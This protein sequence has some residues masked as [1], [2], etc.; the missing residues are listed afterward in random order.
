MCAVRTDR[1]A[2]DDAA[3]VL[4]R[5]DFFSIMAAFPTGVAVVTTLDD[6]GQPRGLSS[7]AFCSVS[8]DPPL[9]LVCVDKNSRTLSALHHSRRFVVN[10][11]REGR[12][13]LCAVF[14]SKADD[15]FAHTV[16]EP[17]DN[18]MPLLVDDAVGYLEC[19]TENEVEAGDHIV[20][21]GRV[22]AGGLDEEGSPLVYCDRTYGRFARGS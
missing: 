1:S 14:A 22:A 18:G 19:V 2:T 20:I 6:E 21:V 10:F 5:T 8:A 16:W 15:K 11:L 13:E 12:R 4:S 3:A 17:A 9:I 7:N